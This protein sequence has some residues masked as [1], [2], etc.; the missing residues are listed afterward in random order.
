M[1]PL[2]RRDVTKGRRDSFNVADD[3]G[4]RTIAQAHAAA[5]KE[6]QRDKDKTN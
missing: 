1:D 5:A 3:S 4:R 6:Q 2:K